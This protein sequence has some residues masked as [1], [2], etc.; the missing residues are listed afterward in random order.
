MRE[1]REGE[2]V[3]ISDGSLMENEQKSNR[4]RD[5]IGSN[6]ESKNR[7]RN[8]VGKNEW[9]VIHGCNTG[10]NRETP[11]RREKNNSQKG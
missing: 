10:T 9:G 5:N 4:I 11:T 7:Q 8:G 3:T 6:S 2:T 1:R